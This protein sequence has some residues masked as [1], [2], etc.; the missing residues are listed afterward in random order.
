MPYIKNIIKET[1]ENTNFRKVVFT[2][3]RSQLVV[4][5]IPVGGEIGQEKHGHVEQTLFFLSGTGKAILNGVEADISAGDVVVVTPSTEH[6][7]INTGSEPLKVY[8]VY[9]P[10]N[11]ID[12]RIHVTKANADADDADEEFGHTAA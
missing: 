9:A 4:M 8:T 10:A 11:H 1:E 2:G 12:G 6:N 7:F 3:D 5:N